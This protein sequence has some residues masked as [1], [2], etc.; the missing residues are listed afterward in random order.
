MTI[1][2]REPVRVS[3]LRRIL[4]VACRTISTV[5]LQLGLVLLFFV[6]VDA[7]LWIGSALFH[8]HDLEEREIIAAYPDIPWL[9]SYIDAFD[10]LRLRWHPYV[11]WLG[12][13]L[14]GAYINVEK[15]GLRS[16]WK[17]KRIADGSRPIK[18]FVFGGSTAWGQGARDNY[19]IPSLLARRLASEIPDEVEVSNFG[20][21][22]YVST[23]E[24]FLLEEQLRN[25]NVPD[26]AIFYDGANDV[27][28]AFENKAPGWTNDEAA[29]GREFNLLNRNS[30]LRICKFA[31]QHFFTQSRTARS[32]TW[33]LQ[34]LS[35]QRWY[36]VREHLI[37][38][39]FRESGMR[40]ASENL[41][42]ELEDGTV[43]AYLSNKHIIEGLSREF[44]FRCLFFWQPMIFTKAR[45]SLYERSVQDE[46]ALYYPGL[47]QFYRE[48]YIRLHK[49]SSREGIVDISDA[50]GDLDKPCYL[51][52]MHTT[53]DAN[54]ILVGNMLPRIR[55]A[56]EDRKWPGATRSRV[57]IW[58]K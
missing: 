6:V 47:E 44:G 27:H 50:F 42:V 53:E 8:A 21:I 4:E 35:P 52:Y 17:D 13:P 15:N 11:Y 20:Q 45:P 48:T 10:T 7:S 5:W 40:N 16:T 56:L 28:S 37:D 57:A 3:V 22:G 14:R 30:R 25:G 23:Q 39:A 34:K 12:A 36:T 19:T 18:I 24:L 46:V 38:T 32:A 51:D 33:L 49:V 55:A 43:R 26:I 29:R 9:S 54:Q 1:S 41:S 31:V 58:S 2:A